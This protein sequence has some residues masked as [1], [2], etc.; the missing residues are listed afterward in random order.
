ME[1]LA[2]QSEN[3]NQLKKGIPLGRYGTVKEV[4]DAT[5]YLFSD[6]AN[7]VNGET[8]VVDGGAWR[9]QRADPGMGFA[10]PDFLLGGDVVTGVKGT[11]KEK[12][13]SKL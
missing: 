3:S 13:K 7:Y 9:L 11:K 4:A 8:L 6:S 2:K 1:R 10:Y 5:V 12:E